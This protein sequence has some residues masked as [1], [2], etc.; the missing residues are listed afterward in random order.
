MEGGPINVRNKR[1][2]KLFLV[3]MISTIY[4]ISFSQLGVSAYDSIM[5]KDEYFAAG[6]KIGSI[7]IEGKTLNEAKKL[8]TDEVAKWQSET[9]I[10]IQYKEKSK[11][12]NV[13]NIYFDIENT[14]KQVK[15]G[16]TNPVIVKINGME[17]FLTSVFSTLSADGIKM[18]ALEAEVLNSAQLL[19][20]GSYPIQLEDFVTD[21]N[22]LFTILEQSA[23]STGES[24]EELEKFV[25]Q[26]IE[27]RPKT[28]FSLLKYIN[29]QGI[30]GFTSVTLN[31]IATS[32][33]GIILPTN[34]TI[35]ERHISNELPEYAELGFEAKVDIKRNNDLVFFNPNK[36][37]YFIEF[38]NKEGTFNVYLKGPSFL[39]QYIIT[40]RDKENFQPKTIRQFNP[41]LGPTEIKVKVEGKEGQL[42][43][44][45]RE[46]IDELGNKIKEELIAEDFYPPIHRV[47]IGG[48][49]INEGQSTTEE[50]NADLSDNE[51][52][53]PDSNN[54][55]ED[56]V[57]H[58]E[59]PL[60]EQPEATG[61]K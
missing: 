1:A 27:I 53:T 54:S 30:G 55:G 39:Y 4:I 22:E 44:V 15:Q 7:S 31:K 28:Q 18:E 38:E 52:K 58:N 32:I 16:Q 34:F 6:T 29:E 20:P 25:G 26:S 21:Q 14:M 47:E 51:E 41:L 42:I 12:F 43:R 40:A 36:F 60:E 57:D 50:E 33:Y 24:Q 56:N 9:S 19:E 8:I 5:H 49:I 61:Q 11:D 10:T 3:L 17:V 45:Y 2:L 46:H 37:S 48:L 59:S 35:I 13:K 23:I